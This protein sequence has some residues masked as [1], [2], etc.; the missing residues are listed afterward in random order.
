MRPNTAYRGH[1]QSSDDLI[2]PYEA[3]RAGFVAQALEKNRRATPHVAEARALQAA[4]S[5]A[6]TPAG[7]LKIE[8]IEAGLLTAALSTIRLPKFF[9]YYAPLTTHQLLLLPH[10]RP[11]AQQ[12][13]LAQN[14]SVPR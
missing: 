6:K 8:G 11:S 9:A 2:T 14:P 1:L 12:A 7:L 10:I 3:I 13:T 4:A 5:S